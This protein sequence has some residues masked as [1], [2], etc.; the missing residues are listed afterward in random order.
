MKQKWRSWFIWVPI[1]A[2]VLL[3]VWHWRH[4]RP[5]AAV[6]PDASSASPS[7][8]PTSAVPAIPPAKRATST[9]GASTSVPVDPDAAMATSDATSASTSS[10]AFAARLAETPGPELGPG[11]TP[12]TVLENMRGMFHQY[13]LRFGANPVGDNQEITRALN[14]GNPGEVVFLN[15]DDGAR[16]NERG[17][18]IDNWGTAYFF[19]QLSAR[20]MEIHSAGPDRQMWTGDD[21]VIK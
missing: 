15:A 13:H 7:A 2:T 1:A 21:L 3:G 12:A 11:L 18:L 6:S 17:E 20:E 16:V 4:P 14:G 8:S 19:H 9:S 10:P 5:V